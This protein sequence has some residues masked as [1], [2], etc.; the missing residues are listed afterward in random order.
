[1]RVRRRRTKV[2]EGHA[3]RWTRARRI[4]LTGADLIASVVAYR[5]RTE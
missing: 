4:R 2:A 1:M 3:R 5:V